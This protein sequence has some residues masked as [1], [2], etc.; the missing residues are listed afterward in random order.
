MGYFANCLTDA[1]VLPECRVD[2]QYFGDVRS[3]ADDV[4]EGI[5]A[6][7]H[8]AAIS[9]DPMGKTFENVTLDVNYRA[10]VALAQKAKAKGVKAFVFA[11]S[12]SMYG[13]GGNSAK[14]EKSELNPLTAYARSKV[15]TEK[16]LEPLVDSNFK[17]TC[18]RFSTACGMSERLRLDL[19]LNDFVAGAVA[20][21]QINILSDGTPWRPLINVKDMA[22]AI[23]WAIIRENDA[24]GLFLAVNIG[25]DEWNYQVKDLAEA[26]A[27]VM[28]DVDVS[29][30]KNAEPDKR[31]YRVD[32]NLYKVLAPNHQPQVDLIDSIGELKQGLESMEFKNANFRNSHFM[33]LKVLTGL[34]EKR[35]LSDTLEWTNSAL[36]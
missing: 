32:F 12:C 21:K 33:R 4:L 10:S 20:S 17:V 26:V 9:N 16:E 3:I 36:V 6:V 8:L 18:L 5:D 15:F 19:V 27:K 31:S 25:S 22:R 24:G 30:N 23:E 35:L 1:I 34:R 2:L 29:I 11:S 7:V 14:T 13:A 28:P